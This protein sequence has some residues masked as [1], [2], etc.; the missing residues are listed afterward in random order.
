MFQI[1][2]HNQKVQGKELALCNIMLKRL[3]DKIFLI[4][5]KFQNL[6][7]LINVFILKIKILI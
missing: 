1:Y 4:L 6:C 5:L 7:N 2:V 3:K